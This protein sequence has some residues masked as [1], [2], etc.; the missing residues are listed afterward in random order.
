ML[1]RV[2]DLIMLIGNE[3]FTTR[4]KHPNK[5]IEAAICFAEMLGWRYRHTGR[6]SHAWGRLLCPRKD[7]EGCF[8]SICS[9]P[10]NPENHAKQILRNV[11]TC[12]HKEEY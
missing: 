4:T 1:T 8:F 12:P 5:E 6:S 2:N 7:R 3:M 10:K 11:K 9:T